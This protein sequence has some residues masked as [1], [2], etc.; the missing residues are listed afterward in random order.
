VLTDCLLLIHWF[1]FH[2]LYFLIMLSNILFLLPLLSLAVYWPLSFFLSFI[3]FLESSLCP[4]HDA[5]SL[6]TPNTPSG[7]NTVLFIVLQIMTAWYWEM[8]AR[9][10]LTPRCKTQHKLCPYSNI[11]C[12]ILLLFL[13]F[14]HFNCLLASKYFIL[15]IVMFLCII[16]PDLAQYYF[17][18]LYFHVSTA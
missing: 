7:S 18:V 6:A 9:R 13:L 3:S 10:T 12:F 15:F 11:R 4:D 1:L 5:N 17:F 8:L 14:I 2:P 16:I